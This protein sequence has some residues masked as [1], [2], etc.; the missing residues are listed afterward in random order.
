MVDSPLLLCKGD[1]M[2]Y[3]ILCLSDWYIAARY[4]EDGTL[5]R[6]SRGGHSKKQA[7]EEILNDADVVFENEYYDGVEDDWE[8]AEDWVDGH[9]AKT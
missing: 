3:K 1:I 4:N 9:F 6:L 8:A 7:L 2:R 5:T